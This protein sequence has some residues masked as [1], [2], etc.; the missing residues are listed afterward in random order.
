M[1]ERLDVERA[2]AKP[3]CDEF[4]HSIETKFRSPHIPNDKC[5]IQ[6]TSCIC[7]WS[8]YPTAPARQA[9]TQRIRVALLEKIA[10]IGLPEPMEALNAISKMESE[11]DVDLSFSR[12][13]WRCDEG[14]HARGMAWLET[15]YAH[16]KVALFDSFKI[17]RE[18]DFRV[19]DIAYGLHLS[20]RSILSDLDPEMTA[21]K[22]VIGQDIP[23][24]MY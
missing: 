15:I 4:F 6:Q 17:Y 10:L 16:E 14:N 11:D 22:A 13:G 19:C 2:L 24:E 3:R 1:G 7:T 23:R 21:D 20:D 8:K 5:R 12:D 18:F 9:L